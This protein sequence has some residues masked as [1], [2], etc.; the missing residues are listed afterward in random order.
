MQSGK[1]NNPLIILLIIVILSLFSALIPP[2]QSPDEFDHIKRAYL[3]GKGQLILDTPTG[4]SSGGDVD[5]GLLKYMKLYRSLP[6]HSDAKVSQE[7]S[8]SAQI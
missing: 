8:T 5:S 4:Q 7:I 3:L 2:F 1:R 6:F